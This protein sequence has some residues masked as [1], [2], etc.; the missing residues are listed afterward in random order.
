MAL[1][2]YL[3]KSKIGKIFAHKNY[4]E[5]MKKK[6]KKLIEM[7]MNTYHLE[8]IFIFLDII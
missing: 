3:L 2:E 1:S 8:L 7:D 6:K 4:K 5:K